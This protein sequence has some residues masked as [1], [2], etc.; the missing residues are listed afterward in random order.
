MK[1]KKITSIFMLLAIL[2]ASVSE[3]ISFN[4]SKIVLANTQEEDISEN[5]TDILNKMTVK[6]KIGQMLILD[7]TGWDDK[8]LTELNDTVSKII[9]DYYLGGVILFSPNIV[10]VEQTVKL[11]NDIQFSAGNK[12]IPLF[13]ATDQEGGLGSRLRMGTNLSGNMSLGAINSTNIAYE[14]GNLIGAELN[15][16]GINLNFAPVLDVNSNPNNPIIGVRSFSSKSEIVSQLGKEVI[17]GLLDTNT[18]P[19]IKHFPGHGDTYTDSHVGLP[20]VDKSRE[21]LD[22]LELVPF[23]DNIN[24][25]EMIM[26]AHIQY[27]QIEKD[28]KNDVY[29]PATLSDD[30]LTGILRDDFNYD[31]IIIT[32]AMDMNAITSNF[33]EVEAIKMAINAGADIALMPT[34]IRSSSDIVKLEK[35][36]S[37]L[38]NS[39]E[40]GE[41]AIERIDE[42]VE[43]I[44]KLK[45]KR[46]IIQSKNIKVDTKIENAKKIVGSNNHRLFERET[47]AKSITVLQNDDVLPLKL[48]KKERILL[49]ST[50]ETKL[51]SMKFAINRLITE[52]VIPNISIETHNY[53][54][55]HLVDEVLNKKIKKSDNIIVL[56]EAYS[57]KDM[58]SESYLR[59]L[60]VD[61]LKHSNKINKN[62]IFVSVGNPYNTGLF[63]EACAQIVT[64]GGW[65]LDFNEPF[66]AYAPNIPAAIDTIFGAYKATGRLPIDIPKVNLDGSL[67]MDNIEFKQGY[68]LDI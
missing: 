66:N 19:V 1:Y 51:N 12:D 37:E 23:K 47:A 45:N 57:E 4:N 40:T 60:P 68:G 14:Y 46:G 18:I 15:A 43:R 38:L 53:K 17:N 6:E 25:I 56:T 61:I 13:I 42:S 39:I 59:T 11:C 7:F 9:S 63:K 34:V 3:V 32:D 21:E 41:I 24:N 64:Y 65:G 54:D 33:G 67:D 50:D 10:N 26:T 55:Q 16:L 29:I 36:F 5:V 49:V 2:T 30:I 8:S 31:G 22:Q 35:I 28:K 27:P 52:N 62:T 20:R 44:L 58:A 48:K